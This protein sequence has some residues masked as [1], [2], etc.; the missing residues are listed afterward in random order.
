M[1]RMSSVPRLGLTPC[2]FTAGLCRKLITVPLLESLRILLVL[3]PDDYAPLT[4]E[5]TSD[6][7]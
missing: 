7:N 6:N 3:M 5:T 1:T 2:K 4:T